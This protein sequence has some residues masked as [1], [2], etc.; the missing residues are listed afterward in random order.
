MTKKQKPNQAAYMVDN[1]VEFIRACKKAGVLP[2][3]R[4]ARKFKRNEGVAFRASG[5]RGA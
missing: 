1:H 2:T 5:R 4:Q 3:K